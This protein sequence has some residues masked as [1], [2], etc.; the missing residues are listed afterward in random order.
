LSDCTPRQRH[1]LPPRRSSDLGWAA[2]AEGCIMTAR[3]GIDRIGWG[4][5]HG[6][7]VELFTLASESGA[8]VRIITFG[9]IIT[10]LVAPDRDGR[11]GDIVLGFD[12]L[13][14]YVGHNPYFGAIV[15][16]V[17]NRIAGGRFEID[18]RMWQL[19]TNNGANHLHGGVRGFD[20]VIWSAEASVTSEGPAVRLSYS[21]PDGE[22][23]YPGAVDATVEYIWTH[24][25]QLKVVME[26]TCDA[27]TAVNLAQHSYF[28][29][30]GHDSGGILDHKLMIEA[31]HYLPVGPGFIPTG[32]FAPVAG[33]PFDF[34]EPKPVGRD[35]GTLPG[36]GVG[37]PGGYDVNYIVRG[38]GAGGSAV[39]RVAGVR[40]PRSGRV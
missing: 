10:E 7:P 36:D 32:A 19:A 28:N 29:L 25:H 2:A 13:E 14:E 9:A 35:I 34:R 31:D 38:G 24:D 21:S 40:G 30:D 27:P 3:T 18:G 15:G 4:E 20:K 37:D 39:R 16:R 23:G 22:E 5:A 8:F 6:R 33:A 11:L 1:S 12:T 17:A 26:A